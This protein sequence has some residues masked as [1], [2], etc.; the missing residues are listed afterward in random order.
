MR[1]PSSRKD[2]PVLAKEPELNPDAASWWFWAFG[3]CSG[4]RIMAFA[5]APTCL[6]LLQRTFHSNRY[7]LVLVFRMKPN[8]VGPVK[9]PLVL[10]LITKG[11]GTTTHVA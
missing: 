8:A 9:K 3:L 1:L 6:C 7:G 5:L 4:F 11:F 2:G 10:P